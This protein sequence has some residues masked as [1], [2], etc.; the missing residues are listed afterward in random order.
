VPNQLQWLLTLV[1]F[2]CLTLAACNKSG[3]SS[4]GAQLYASNI[5][6]NC[7]GASLQGLPTLGPD[8][9]GV[10]KHW[11]SAAELSKYFEDPREYALGDQRLREGL[12]KYTMKMP[13]YASMS[14]EDRLALAEWLLSQ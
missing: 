13:S 4:K 2:I 14:E 10:K 8:L 12:S 5:C 7:H 1:L 11:K 3:G 9:T 6:A